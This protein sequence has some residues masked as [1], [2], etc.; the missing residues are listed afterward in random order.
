MRGKTGDRRNVSACTQ[1][2]RR[3]ETRET[4]KRSV[5]PRFFPRFFR[6]CGKEGA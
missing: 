3:S 4:R 1:H 6:F 2:L 5:C